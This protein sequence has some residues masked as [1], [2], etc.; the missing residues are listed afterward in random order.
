MEFFHFT[1][2]MN[3]KTFINSGESL[4]FFASFALFAPL[5]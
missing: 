1:Q 3:D 4:I 5:R 2:K